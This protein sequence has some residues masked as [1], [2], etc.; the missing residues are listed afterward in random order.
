ML[1]ALH[2]QLHLASIE[3]GDRHVAAA[4]FFV[5]PFATSCLDD[6]VLVDIVLPT[7]GSDESWG[8]YKLK[9]AE[10]SWPIGVA[11]ACVRP[12]STGSGGS[13]TVTLGA[14]TATPLELA[15]LQLGDRSTMNDTERSQL[16]DLIFGADPQWWSDELAD[17]NYRR[18]VAGIVAA[19]SIAAAITQRTS[20]D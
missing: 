15:P 3:R 20:N 6:E 12:D 17:A 1:V 16:Q 13:A 14:L 2:A 11:A 9:T 8:R 5:G 18:R 19:R 4:D 7:D 10:G